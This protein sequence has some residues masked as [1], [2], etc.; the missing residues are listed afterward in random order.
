MQTSPPIAGLP[1]SAPASTCTVA[2]RPERTNVYADGICPPVSDGASAAASRGVVSAPP[3][4]IGIRAVLGTL[5]EAATERLSLA[6]SSKS[7]TRQAS[8]ED[9]RR[10]VSSMA[11]RGGSVAATGGCEFALAAASNAPEG[12]LWWPDDVEPA[13]IVVLA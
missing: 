5:H 4:P 11:R 3:S 10:A 13:C 1:G 2:R 6:G 7:G 8:G 9:P 12:I